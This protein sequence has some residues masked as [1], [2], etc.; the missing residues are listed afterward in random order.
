MRSRWSNVNGWCDL[1]GYDLAV[2]AFGNYRL[3]RGRGITIRKTID[4]IIAT[5]CIEDGLTLLH[6][7]R[8]LS[9]FAAHLG[10]KVAY[11]EA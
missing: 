10:L 11:S 3:L 4:T 7:D 5:R 2:K 6:A 1:G 9:P 8:D